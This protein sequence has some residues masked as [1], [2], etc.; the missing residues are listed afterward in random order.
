MR[1]ENIHL[2]PG[3]GATMEGANR[4]SGRIAEAQYLGPFT[5][6]VV[7]AAGATLRSYAQLDLEPGAEVTL[8]I[9][10]DDI[11]LLPAE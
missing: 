11:V 4:L 9:A 8:A 2:H 3:A 6:Y 10:P 1:P 5:E 7:E